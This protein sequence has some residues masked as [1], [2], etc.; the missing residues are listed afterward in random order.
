MEALNQMQAGKAVQG[1]QA[2]NAAT[3]AYKQSAANLVTNNTDQMT[4]MRTLTELSEKK[5]CGPPA[6]MPMG[7][8]GGEEND[9]EAEEDSALIDKIQNTVSGAAGMTDSVMGL[10]KKKK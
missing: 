2:G 7:G 9:D 10:F 4:R 6:G 8:Y 1:G 5:G 3:Q